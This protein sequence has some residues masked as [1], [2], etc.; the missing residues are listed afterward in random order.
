MSKRLAISVLRTHDVRAVRL[1]SWFVIVGLLPFWT[2]L[3]YVLLESKGSSSDY[4]TGAPWLIVASIPFSAATLVIAAITY[5]VFAK[6]EGSAFRKLRYGG[7][8]FTLLSALLLIGVGFHWSRY[9]AK[10]ERNRKVQEEGR[11]L[12]ERNALVASIAPPG[13][14]VGLNS[15]GFDRYGELRSLTYHVYAIGD[16]SRSFMAIVHVLRNSEASQLRVA[17]VLAERDYTNLQA[18][19][20]PC[21][22]S[23]AIASQ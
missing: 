21:Q 7:G 9:A 4:W 2:A 19:H 22:F 20:D 8:C 10:E 1:A 14:R 13:F 17:C 23:N 11:A 15:S 12:V 6:T 16:S 18:G 3:V 5:A